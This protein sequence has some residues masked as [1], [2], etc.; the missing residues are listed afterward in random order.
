MRADRPSLDNVSVLGRAALRSFTV[1]LMLLA[2]ALLI[3]VAVI[4]LVTFWPSGG[5]QI[6]AT[7]IGNQKTYEGKV[8]EL[9]EIA[10]QA[11]NASGCI[12]VAVRLQGGPD[13]G[14]KVGFTAGNTST[15]ATF[16]IGETLLAVPITT[17]LAAVLATHVPPGLTRRA[18]RPRSLSRPDRLVQG[19][20]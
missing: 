8:V 19:R 16:S 11:P 14:E 15:D 6:S 10:C 7:A 3:A 1:Q 20:R 5:R 12:R 4:G 2:V 13:K 18:T 17:T 9:H